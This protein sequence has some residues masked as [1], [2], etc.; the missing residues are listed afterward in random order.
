MHTQGL[1]P[2]AACACA[3]PRSDINGKKTTVQKPRRRQDFR[4]THKCYYCTHRLLPQCTTTRN[5]EWSTRRLL[6]SNQ[7][8]LKQA[9]PGSGRSPGS[10]TLNVLHPRV[11]KT[12]KTATF[13]GWLVLPPGRLPRSSLCAGASD[14][15]P[16]SP[17]HRCETSS[18][19]TLGVFFSH[20]SPILISVPHPVSSH[21][22]LLQHETPALLPG[23]TNRTH[24]GGEHISRKIKSKGATTLPAVYWVARH[25]KNGNAEK[26]TTSP[27]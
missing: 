6:I 24:P 11:H 1:P 5:N 8:A 4:Q 15:C 17:S 20:P 27:A 13:G 3:Y 2:L 7:S 14:L 10:S 9:S 22:Y 21:T 12:E 25:E 19:S 16:S 18:R 23:T 26:A